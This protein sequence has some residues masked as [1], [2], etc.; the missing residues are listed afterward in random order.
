MPLNSKYNSDFQ[1]DL[2]KALREKKLLSPRAD[3]SITK[4]GKTFY[5][6]Y[7]S[8]I[9]YV[10]LTPIT[11]PMTEKILILIERLPSNKRT[12]EK[13]PLRGDIASNFVYIL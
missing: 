1:I 11:I 7:Y 12:D 5:R 2:L 8:S 6:S 13:S 4:E 3:G 10:G 9:N